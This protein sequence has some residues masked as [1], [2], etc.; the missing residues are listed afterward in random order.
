M[1]LR[2][3]DL[4]GLGMPAGLAITESAYVSNAKAAGKQSRLTLA[5]LRRYGRV[6]GYATSF[7]PKDLAVTPF[8]VE[9]GADTFRTVKGTAD[10]MRYVRANSTKPIRGG[11]RWRETPIPRIGD[12][13][14]AYIVAITA[15]TQYE[16]VQV[17]WRYRTALAWVSIAGAAKSIDL[18]TAL[19]LAR[20]QQAHMRTSFAAAR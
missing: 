8:A 9:S 15:A 18:R 11:I 5:Q 13:A 1:V 7:E 4:A 14:Q 16:A 6:T 12:E 19:R 20:R 17:F 2:P 3:S 10:A